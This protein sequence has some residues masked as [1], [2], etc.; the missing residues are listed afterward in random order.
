MTDATE[1][2]DRMVTSQLAARGIQSPAVLDAMRAV[3]RHLF[4]P[5]VTVERAYSDHALPTTGG[6]TISQPYIVARMTE[7]LSVQPGMSVLEIGTGSGYQT[8]VLAYLGARIV[9]IESNPDLLDRARQVLAEVCPADPGADPGAGG[10]GIRLLL[11]DGTRGYPDD[12]PYDRILVTAAAPRVPAAYKS[13]IADP[14]RIVIP[15]GDRHT[16]VLTVIERMGE[17]FTQIEDIACRFV[18]LVGEDG[19]RWGSAEG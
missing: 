8:A 18:P 17:Q 3:P 4:V 1:A 13:Q 5:D 2:A 14:G 10:H 9:T 16:Q 19:W 15:L 11:A 7:L 12:A 6:Q